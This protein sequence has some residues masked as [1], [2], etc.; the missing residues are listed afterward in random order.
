M[1]LHPISKSLEKQ[2]FNCCLTIFVILEEPNDPNFAF[3]LF[4]IHALL[5]F[6]MAGAVSHL[7]NRIDRSRTIILAYESIFL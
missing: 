1:I 3:S 6:K 4:S 5:N 7:V 2:L